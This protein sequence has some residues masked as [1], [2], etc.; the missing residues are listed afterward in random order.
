MAMRFVD[1]SVWNAVKVKEMT[2]KEIRALIKDAKSL[3]FFVHPGYCTF[4]DETVF[5]VEVSKAWASEF[6]TTVPVDDLPG[7][8]VIDYEGEKLMRF[9]PKGTFNVISG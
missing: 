5:R 6:V 3:Q 7:I 2:K 8:Q 4:T 9:W 1:P